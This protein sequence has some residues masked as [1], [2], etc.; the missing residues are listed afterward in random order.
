MPQALRHELLHP[1]KERKVIREQRGQEDQRSSLPR[2]RQPSC[3]QRQWPPVWTHLPL[4]T[5]GRKVLKVDEQVGVGQRAAPG[6]LARFLWHAIPV[7]RRGLS[8]IA[9][10]QHA[11]RLLKPKVP[12]RR[13]SSPSKRNTGSTVAHASCSLRSRRHTGCL[14]HQTT[15]ESTTHNIVAQKCQPRSRRV[16]GVYLTHWPIVLGVLWDGYMM[17]YLD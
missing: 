17:T 7:R 4:G 5:L 3:S 14:M 9:G 1:P 13:I 2:I 10:T 8:A 12:S 16:T 11:P 15:R 6:H